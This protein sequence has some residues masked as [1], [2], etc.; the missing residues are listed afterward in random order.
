MLLTKALRPILTSLKKVAFITSRMGSIEDNSSG[1][2]YGYRMSK[3][4]LNMAAK[5][6]SVDLFEKEIAVGIIH[7][8]WVKTRMTNQHA[9]LSVAESSQ[10]ILEQID[11]LNMANTGTFW[12][13]KGEILPW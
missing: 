2:S 10:L 8:G 1:N 12:H 5:S 6:L 13:A 3:A 9:P 11:K 4:A 7:P